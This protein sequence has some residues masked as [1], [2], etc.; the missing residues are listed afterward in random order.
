MNVPLGGGAGGPGP[1][2]DVQ[3]VHVVTGRGRGRPVPAVGHQDGVAVVDLFTE[4]DR[5]A[6]RGRGAEQAQAGLPVRSGGDLEV[7]DLLQHRLGGAGLVVLVR[8]VGRPVAT[9]G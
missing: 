1:G 8:R 7:V 2:H 4:V 6:G 5:V 3:V 9:R